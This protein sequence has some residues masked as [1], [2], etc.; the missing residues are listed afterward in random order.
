MQKNPGRGNPLNS[1]LVM[2][3]VLEGYT[4]QEIADM[5]EI[6]RDGVKR[7]IKQLYKRFDCNT[8]VELAVKILI[9]NAIEIDQALIDR[10]VPGEMMR[11]D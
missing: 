2:R 6:T 11:N 4:N 5:L 7:H 10:F 3:H 8:R 1:E 9:S